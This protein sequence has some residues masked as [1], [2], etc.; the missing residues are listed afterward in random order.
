MEPHQLD[1][2]AAHA[3]DGRLEFPEPQFFSRARYAPEPAQDQAAE[4]LAAAVNFDD[5]RRRERV[6]E[7]AQPD[8]AGGLPLDVG[9]FRELG[10][11]AVE[12]V[13]NLAE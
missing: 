8:C 13:A 6:G 9:N 3:L 10:N 1:R 2:R 5:P 11:L 12:L 7:L 4:R